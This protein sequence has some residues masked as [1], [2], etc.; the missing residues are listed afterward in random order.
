MMCDRCG[1]RAMQTRTQSDK[2]IVFAVQRY[3]GV[4]GTTYPWVPVY[5]HLKKG[6]WIQ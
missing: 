2:G 1:Q 3:C 6:E 4:C 5:P